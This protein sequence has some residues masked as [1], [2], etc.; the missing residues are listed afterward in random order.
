MMTRNNK[1][2]KHLSTLISVF[3]FKI[4]IVILMGFICDTLNKTGIR[5]GTMELLEIKCIFKLST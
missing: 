5:I 2:K 3:S 1:G 4:L